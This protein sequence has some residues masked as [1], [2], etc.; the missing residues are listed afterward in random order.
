MTDVF[1]VLFSLISKTSLDNVVQRWVP[2]I[3]HYCPNAPFMLVG[4]KMDMREDDQVV[5]TLRLRGKMVVN[6]EDGLNVANS[7]GAYRYME[8]SAMTQKGLHEVFNEA[9]RS[10]VSPGGVKKGSKKKKKGCVLL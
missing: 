10:V 5:E 4:T 3:K 8:C 1:L 2:E 7:V 9:I 6:Y